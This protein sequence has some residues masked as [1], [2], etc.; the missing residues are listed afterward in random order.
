MRKLLLL[1]LIPIASLI[2]W[3]STVSPASAEFLV[4]CS[5]SSAFQQRKSQAPDS[6]YFNKPFE[7]YGS[8]LVCGEDG[9]PHLPIRL[10]RFIDVLIPFGIFLYTAGFIGWSGRSYLQAA[11][12]S[13]NPE[14]KEIF[15][16][17]PMAIQSFIKGLLWPLLFLQELTTGQLTAKD[18]EIPVS[19][20]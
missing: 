10:D 1:L 20:R 9:L 7:V 12:K 18:N 3:S 17:L 19:P 2:L 13:S 16:D 6:Y 4:P 8:E 11:N 5:Q 15:I 14:E